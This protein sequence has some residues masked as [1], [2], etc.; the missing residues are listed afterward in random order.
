MFDPKHLH[1]AVA[2]DDN[3]AR[4][5]ATLI[6]STAKSNPDFE[7]ITFHLL[8]NGIKD[9]SLQKIKDVSDSYHNCRLEVCDVSNL[10]HRLVIEVPKTIALTSYARLFMPEII[11]KSISRILYLDTDIIVSDDLSLLWN[12]DLENNYIGGCLDVF[13]GTE[14]KTSVGLNPDDP[15]IN[16]GVLLIDL[17]AWRKIDLPKQFIKFL[18]DHNGEVHH[19]DQGII[20]GVCK[21][22]I[23]ILPPQYNMHSTVYSHPFHLIKKITNP[24]YT[25]KEY[26]DAIEKPM[27]IH[28]TEG[29]YNRPWKDNCQHPM[30]KKFID[31]QNST[32]W[33]GTALIPDNR[34]YV[35]KLL[36]W[37]FLNTNYN[38]YRF[39]ST[40][41]STLIKLFKR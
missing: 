24:Y 33:V 28:F 30:R 37:T 41:L 8:A 25:E 29:F 31:A 40:I 9:S 7:T 21:G 20:N 38:I 23:L 3:Y 17:D 16:A 26:N 5:V 6:V 32:P 22:H 13:E 11:D 14:S 27:I 34:S 19:H 15:Y 35:V 4:F 36:S 12:V 39:L 18:Y 10:A 1:I 2:S